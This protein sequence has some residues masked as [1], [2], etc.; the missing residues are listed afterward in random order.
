[1]LVRSLLFWCSVASLLLHLLFLPRTAY[2][3]TVGL[4][5]VATTEY[6]LQVV[7]KHLGVTVGRRPDQYRLY[8]YRFPSLLAS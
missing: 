5:A 1:M 3:S 7:D 2:S 6:M 8:L 4:L